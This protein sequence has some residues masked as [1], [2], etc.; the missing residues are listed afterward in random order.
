MFI[1]WASAFPPHF[2]VRP[3]S[4]GESS[5]HHHMIPGSPSF[6][7]CV[8]Y[9]SHSA[10]LLSI[11]IKQNQMIP[12]DSYSRSLSLLITFVLPLV[13]FLCLSLANEY[14]V[15]HNRR[16]LCV[17]DGSFNPVPRL[18]CWRSAVCV[19]ALPQYSDKPCSQEPS[20]S[21]DADYN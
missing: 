18:L 10:L 20:V 1:S 9:S 6:A 8:V 12:Q 16:P 2:P 5:R 13:A 14:R 3:A 21:N 7:V 15:C 4:Q 19:F 11:I 17:E